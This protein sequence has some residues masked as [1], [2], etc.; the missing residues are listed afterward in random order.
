VDVEGKIKKNRWREPARTL[1]KKKKLGW[2]GITDHKK[3]EAGR[4]IFVAERKK[5]DETWRGEQKKRQKD[6]R[7][8]KESPSSRYRKN[9]HRV[10][11]T[12][13]KRKRISREEEN[14]FNSLRF[15]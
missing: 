10:M 6:A 8:R 11:T 3:N 14:V 9:G 12:G 2:R 1:I 15:R 7:K 13:E 4:E 5:C